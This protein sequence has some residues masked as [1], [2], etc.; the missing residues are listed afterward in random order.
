MDEGEDGEVAEVCDE[1]TA[2]QAAVVER[3]VK[4]GGDVHT[5]GSTGLTVPLGA[6]GKCTTTKSPDGGTGRSGDA[7]VLQRLTSLRERVTSYVTS[8]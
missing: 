8:R 3:A 7:V 1:K 5:E 4:A 2:A 6:A